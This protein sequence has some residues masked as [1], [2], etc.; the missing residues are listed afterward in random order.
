MVG[1]VGGVGSGK[2][3]LARAMRNCCFAVV[4]DGDAAGHRALSDAFAKAELVR[5]FGD[6]ILAADGTIDRKSLARLVFG[7]SH[8][9]RAAKQ[10]LESITHPVIERELQQQIVEARRAK[11]ALIL[12]DAAVLLEAG[13]AKFCDAIIFVEATEEARR[14]RALARGWSEDEWRR[15]E[16]AQL[17]LAEKQ[18]L[19]DAVIDNSVSIDSAVENLTV[20]IERLCRV[21]LDRSTQT[22]NAQTE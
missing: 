22:V 11:A 19:A 18:N 15:R 16:A 1:L 20:T 9:H 12:L 6:Q 3:T 17:S 2:S 21:T 10:R 13:W 4:V 8:E 5:T 7:S 14:S